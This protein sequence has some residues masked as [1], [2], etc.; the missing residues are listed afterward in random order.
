MAHSSNWEILKNLSV[1]SAY[2]QDPNLV[3]IAHADGTLSGMKSAADTVQICFAMAILLLM[4]YYTLLLPG[5]VQL[6]NESST[7]YVQ[8]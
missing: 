8:A 6:L 5:Y 4:I 3:E 1:S 2:T 7:K